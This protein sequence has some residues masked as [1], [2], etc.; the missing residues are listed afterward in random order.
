MIYA[1][2]I[3]EAPG[4]VASAR[5]EYRQISREW[6]AYLGFSGF[7]RLAQIQPTVPQT[8][9]LRQPT[10]SL[11]NRQAPLKRKVLGELPTQTQMTKSNSNMYLQEMQK[12]GSQCQPPWKPVRFQG[13]ISDSEKVP[14]L[15][16]HRP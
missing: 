13:D 7:K 4:H 12:P 16:R 15:K 5:A 2:G 8:F 6:H 11:V 1:R 9:D 3:E 10:E 14:A